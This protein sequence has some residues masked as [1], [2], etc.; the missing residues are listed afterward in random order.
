MTCSKAWELCSRRSGNPLP[1]SINPKE[2]IPSGQGQADA[3]QTH[4]WDTQMKHPGT[5]NRHLKT[6]TNKSRMKQIWDPTEALLLKKHEPLSKAFKLPNP[7]F[8]SIKW[9][10]ARLCR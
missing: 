6:S 9:N 8:S 7:L 3:R 1:L 10:N 5:V 2:L 4:M